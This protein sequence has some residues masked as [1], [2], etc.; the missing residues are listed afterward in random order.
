MPNRRPLHALVGAVTATA[1]VLALAAPASADS[2]GLAVHSLAESPKEIRA[3]W[4][5]ARMRAAEPVA[6]PASPSA[7]STDAPAQTAAIPPDQETN[8]ALDVLYPQRVHGRLFFELD[9]PKTCSAT[10]VSS[11]DEDLIVTAGHCVAIPGEQSG[12]AGIIFAQSVL[13]R[14]AYRNGAEP[15]GTFAGT[16]VAA[17]APWAQSGDISFD[18]GAIE[19]APSAFGKVEE[20]LGARGIAFNRK[21]RSFRNDI[22][23]IY[24]YPA[25][26]EPDYDGERMILCV[27]H[28]QG[29]EPFTSAPVIGPCHQQQGSSGAGW[30]RNGRVESVT[31]HAHAGCPSPVGCS[32]V[33]GSYFGDAEFDVYRKLGGISKGKSKRLKRCKRAESKSKRRACRGKVQRFAPSGA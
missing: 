25:M 17:P 2:Q 15:F 11:Q 14:P 5:P 13:F 33:S 18:F 28:F 32:L 20:L 30:V 31:S 24:G 21:P 7:A 22:F 23:E 26:P 10:V 3:H 12:G 9:G 29:F 4:T 19:L 1:A 27:S 8:P 6:P 16:R